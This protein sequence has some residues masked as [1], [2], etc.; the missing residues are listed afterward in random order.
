MANDKPTSLNMRFG[1]DQHRAS[2]MGGMRAPR[3][4]N[5]VNKITRENKSARTATDHL[6]DAK[7]DS[8]WA[9]LIRHRAAQGVTAEEISDEIYWIERYARARKRYSL[10][11]CL[12]HHWPG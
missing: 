7:N 10:D 6:R 12:K 8:D 5:Q 11:W 4:P 3:S 2:G 1:Y 9:R